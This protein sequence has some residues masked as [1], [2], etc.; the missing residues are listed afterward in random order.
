METQDFLK[1]KVEEI[2]DEIKAVRAKLGNQADRYI[3][4]L[5]SKMESVLEEADAELTEEIEEFKELGLFGWIAANRKAS[6]VIALLGC[7]ALNG[8]LALFGM[9]FGL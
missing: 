7:G 3:G 5:E 6:A 9:H 8:V 2:Q 4:D 1:L